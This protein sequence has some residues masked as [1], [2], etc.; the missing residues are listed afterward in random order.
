MRI[1]W[2]MLY[3]FALIMVPFSCTH[4]SSIGSTAL[5]FFISSECSRGTVHESFCWRDFWCMYTCQYSLLLFL[6]C[7][8]SKLFFC[9]STVLHNYDFSKQRLPVPLYTANRASAGMFGVVDDDHMVSS[10]GKFEIPLA[11]LCS[12]L[13]WRCDRRYILVEPVW[14]RSFV[15]CSSSHPYPRAET[16]VW[17]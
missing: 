6:L 17:W 2:W 16:G 15:A 14:R 7:I 5:A 12:P 8:F 4:C 10:L 1:W 9:F 13:S 11:I 3:A